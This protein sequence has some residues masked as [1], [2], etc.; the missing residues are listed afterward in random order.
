MGM[1]SYI[2]LVITMEKTLKEVL[3]ELPKYPPNSD[4]EE[5]VIKNIKEII[6]KLIKA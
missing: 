3:S 5:L 4:R 1:R 6:E 2:G